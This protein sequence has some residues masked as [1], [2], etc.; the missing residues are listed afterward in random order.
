M[1]DWL[2]PAKFLPANFQHDRYGTLL[3]RFR[4][5]EN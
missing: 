3:E 4:E 1:I 2:I 5:N